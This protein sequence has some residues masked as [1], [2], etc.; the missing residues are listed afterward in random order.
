M[1][2]LYICGDSFG[3]P[4]LGWPFAPWPELLQQKLI[5][6]HR[7]TN[8]SISCASNLLIRMQVD[9]AIEQQAD[10]VILQ[11]TSSTRQQGKTG[12]SKTHT[13]LFDR[14]VK[15]GAADNLGASRDL[16]C[17]SLHSLDDSCV[18]DSDYQKAISNYQSRLF[19]LELEIYHNQCIIESIL[20]RLVHCGIP[21]LFDQG[22]FENPIFGDVNGKKYF[23][24]F[25]KF[26]SE[27]NQWT[28]AASMP[29][30]TTTHFHI[31]DQQVHDQIASYYQSKIAHNHL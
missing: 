21:F 10:F 28:L 27:I 12:R 16:A 3:C 2:R 8:L 26:R 29:K 23:L 4:D 11:C 1:K 31:L 20:H 22:G 9:R 6:S 5:A 18:F 25:D 24:E 19:D 13:A 17:Y 7:V 14:F 30:S 15:I